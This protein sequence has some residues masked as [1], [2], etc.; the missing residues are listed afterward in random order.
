MLKDA[1]YSEHPRYKRK[2]SRESWK[3][4]GVH[5]GCP[6]LP[7]PCEHHPYD[8]HSCSEAYVT[9]QFIAKERS[10]QEGKSLSP[11][12]RWFWQLSYSNFHRVKDFSLKA[13]L[14]IIIV[15]ANTG[16]RTQPQSMTRAKP[17]PGYPADM[18]LLQPFK[19]TPPFRAVPTTEAPHLR[20]HHQ[21]FTP[22]HLLPLL[23]QMVSCPHNPGRQQLLWGTSR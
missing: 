3:S 8:N 22:L 7:D 19:P 20:R 17:C 10:G 11:T 23:L 4:K 14:H 1:C 16:V 6:V 15:L 9:V 5:Q 21:S 2:H 18:A 13:S 12:A